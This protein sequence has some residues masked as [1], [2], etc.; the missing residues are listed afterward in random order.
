MDRNGRGALGWLPVLTL[1]VL[2]FAIFADFFIA[3][4]DRLQG[5]PQRIFYIH[6]PSAWVAFFR[7]FPGLHFFD[8][9]S[10]YQKP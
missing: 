7:L 10:G 8:Q 4:T 2:A 6:V 9:I 3:G 5:P 1:V